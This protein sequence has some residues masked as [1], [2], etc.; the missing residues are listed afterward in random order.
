MATI[1]AHGGRVEFRPVRME[2][3]APR[4]GRPGYRWVEGYQVVINGREMS[5]YMRKREAR[6]FAA[7]E[8]ARLAGDAA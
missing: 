6:D 5:P 3:P 1:K 8:I 2:I 7:R 4:K